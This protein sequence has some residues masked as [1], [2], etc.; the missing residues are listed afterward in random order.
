[1]DWYNLKLFLGKIL[2]LK[3]CN[4]NEKNDVFVIWFQIQLNLH[5]IGLDSN[6]LRNEIQINVKGVENFLVNIML[7]FKKKP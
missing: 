1:L 4:K 5:A 6:F 7:I 2:N 3:S